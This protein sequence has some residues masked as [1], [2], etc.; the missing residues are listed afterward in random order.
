[1]Y[2]VTVHYVTALYIKSLVELVTSWLFCTRSQKDEIKVSAGPDF[3]MKELVD[4]K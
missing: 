2:Y 1:M 4:H 3:Y